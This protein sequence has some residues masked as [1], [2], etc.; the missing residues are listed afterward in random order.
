M[1]MNKINNNIARA[2]ELKTGL[3]IIIKSVKDG[4]YV[5]RADSVSENYEIIRQFVIF[6]KTYVA[7]RGYDNGIDKR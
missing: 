4:L 6:G 2:R 5:S 1:E 3:D 7:Y